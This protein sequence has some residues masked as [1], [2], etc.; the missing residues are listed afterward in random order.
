MAW[1]RGSH[2][3]HAFLLW[4]SVRQADVRVLELDDI[5]VLGTGLN[6]GDVNLTGGTLELAS[7][8]QDG[9]RVLAALHAHTGGT[10]T[11]E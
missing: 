5:L 9:L 11:C 10:D 7:A 1:L 4:V 3:T 2:A 6:D 8:T